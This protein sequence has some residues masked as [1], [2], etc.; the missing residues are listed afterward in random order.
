[1]NLHSELEALVLEARSYGQTMVC[2]RSIEQLLHHHDLKR[3]V[4]RPDLLKESA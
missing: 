1:V 4:F 3:E 2:C